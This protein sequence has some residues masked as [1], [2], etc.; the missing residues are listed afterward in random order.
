[1]T[2]KHSAYSELVSMS[3]PGDRRQSFCRRKCRIED[4][5]FFRIEL[6]P[7]F[8]FY[9]TVLKGTFL[10]VIQL[11]GHLPSTERHLSGAPYDLR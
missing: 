7:A 5:I 2:Q 9:G 4:G 3:S 1:M 6:W 10:K 8:H 11:C